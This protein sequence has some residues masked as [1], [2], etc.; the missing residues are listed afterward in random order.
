MTPLWIGFAVLL[1]LA[2][3][4]LVLPLRQ[5]RRLHD[6]LAEDEA[7]DTAAEQN[8][9]IFKRRK[10]SLDAARERGDIDEAQY[11]EDR[12]ELERSLLD[13]TRR[14]SHRPLGNASAGR[15]AVPL[16]MVGVVLASVFWYQQQG[17]EGD[18]ALYAVQQ[19]VQNDPEGSLST[20]LERMEAQAERQPDNPSVWGELF[21]LYRQTNQPEK[22]ADALERLIELEGRQASLL[23]QLAQIRFFMAD[24]ELTAEVQS[25]VDEIR[26]KDPREPTMLGVMGI[27]AFESGDY[28]AAIDRWRR[29]VANVQ[30]PDTVES[31][32]Q[33]IE[34]AQQRLGIEPDAAGDAGHGV[35]VKV[36]LDDS[37]RDQAPNDATV[38]IT[39]RDLEGE[40]PPLAVVRTTVSALP[41]TVTLSEN[42]AMSPQAS[43]AGEDS[44]RLVV[45]VSPSGQAT[46]QPGD[47]F[48]DVDNVSVGALEGSDTVDVT[49]NRVFK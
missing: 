48:G 7:N 39:A 15:I 42:D 31:L 34:V 33:G 12:L 19:D 32:K 6:T 41:E 23:A 37:L 11:E 8:V 17:A 28:K 25:L 21:P 27:H 49:V 35:S 1:A 9:A 2:L 3:W 13:D 40:K 14:L 36:A 45:R 24:R 22:A 43:I 47:L 18:L 26:Q 29:A 20:Y 10:A 46:P 38:F 44:V 4:F 16:I 30:N 5:S